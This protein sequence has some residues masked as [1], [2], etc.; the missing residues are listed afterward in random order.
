MQKL[1]T[2]TTFILLL[3]SICAVS[4][5]GDAFIKNF[6][7][8]KKQANQIWALEQDWNGFIYAAGRKGLFS[9]DGKNWIKIEIPGYSTVLKR[10]KKNKKIFVGCTGNFG[11]LNMTETGQHEYISISDTDS[12]KTGIITYICMNDTSIFFHSDKYIFEYNRK[13]LLLEKK[14]S[15]G[16]SYFTGMIITP[17][18]LFFNLQDKGLHRLEADTL[19]PIV[20]GYLTVNQEILFYIPYND[21]FTIVGTT[22]NIVSLFDGIKFNDFIIDKSNYL[23]EN[24]LVNG[25]QLNDTTYAFGTLAGGV[26]LVNKESKEIETIIDYQKGLPDNEVFTTLS[27]Q[28]NNLWI[29]HDYGLS[30]VNNSVPI[31]DYSNYPGLEGLI[32]SVDIIDSTIYASTNEGLYFLNKIKSYNDKEVIVKRLVQQKQPEKIKTPPLQEKEEEKEAKPTI[33][34]IFSRLF[35]K[36]GKT[37]TEEEEKKIDQAE[38]EH[39]QIQP[40]TE[41][42]YSR[43][44]VKVLSSIDYAYS[45]VEGISTKVKDLF[46]IDNSLFAMTNTGFYSIK[47]GKADDILKNIYLDQILYDDNKNIFY[48]I[49][50]YHLF[51]LKKEKGKWIQSNPYYSFGEAIYSLLIKDNRLWAGGEFEIFE[52]DISKEPKLVNSYKSFSE[53]PKELIVYSIKD[54]LFYI[55][56]ESFYFF[57][58]DSGRFF[59]H[60]AY[61]NAIEDQILHSD[62]ILWVQINKKWKCLNDVSVNVPNKLLSYFDDISFLQPTIDN[63]WIINDNHILKI[64]LNRFYS[65]P[66]ISLHIT[67][68]TDKKGNLLQVDKIK[69]SPG[70]ALLTFKL[71]APGFIKPEEMLFQ[72]KLTEDEN[73]WSEWVETN[74]ITL[75]LPPGEHT[76]SFRAKNAN[77]SFSNIQVVDITIPKPFTS[78]FW[79]YLII[80]IAALVLFYFIIKLREKKLKHDKMILEQKVKE[81]TIEIQEQKEE[82]ESQRDAIFKQKEEIT[83]SIEY[84]SRIQTALLPIKD[85][86]ENAFH[87]SFILYKPRD[88][89][90][91]DFYWI[92]ENEKKIF[93]TA[94]DCTGHGVPGA[95]MSMLGISILNEIVNNHHHLTANKMLNILREKVKFTL[96]QTGKEGEAKDGMDI[97]LCIYHK[98]KMKLEYS[99]AYNPLLHIRKGEMTVYKADRMPIGIFI[100]EKDSF[101]NQIIDLKKG[102]QIYIFS[103]GFIDQFG[104][105]AGKKYKL[106]QL[107]DKLIEIHNEDMPFQ[108]KKL[109]KEFEDWK[110]NY[111]QVDDII[112]MG[113]RF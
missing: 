26:I 109:E 61:T 57:N 52:F 46:A 95:F 9:F 15:A 72:Y 112:L 69:V 81:R 30:F 51:T 59:Q 47:D 25:V 90:S 7:E 23:Y 8:A 35:K 98:D 4:Q 83:S 99:G 27:D 24:I 42:R 64:G 31:K 76:I 105:D 110:G 3:S 100:K 89:V 58:P 113:I 55:D 1:R 104:G 21:E 17:E 11:Y 85:H 84:A 111:S 106:K 2:L 92:S 5:E 53:I 66:D 78:T 96:H 54:T 63:F 108:Y 18:N 70:D 10:D 29:A 56:E 75:M 73:S 74:I 80:I 65:L 101:T 50:D 38:N 28:Q 43:K 44:T 77:D 16:E 48:I 12:L 33:K 82:I 14:W 60:E 49:G 19:F 88:I 20:T 37:E 107:K 68:I 94:A 41:T 97:A 6:P 71:S 39:K 34:R 22:N 67:K 79:F 45:K 103:D 102:D 62:K 93:F 32:S 40:K 13:D 91:G 86:F 36:G 87:D